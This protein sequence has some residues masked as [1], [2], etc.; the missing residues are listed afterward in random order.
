M[1]EREAE[2]FERDEDGVDPWDFCGPS[3]DS[4]ENSIIHRHF[5]YSKGPTDLVVSVYLLI[6]THTSGFLSVAIFYLHMILN[7]MYKKSFGSHVT[8]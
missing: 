1:L 2:Q 6:Y 3:S 4:A 8:L 5:L 7:C